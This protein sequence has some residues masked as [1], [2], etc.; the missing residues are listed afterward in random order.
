VQLTAHEGRRALEKK[1]RGLAAAI[2]RGSAALDWRMSA[3]CCTLQNQSRALKTIPH[4]CRRS[5]IAN[6]PIKFD[7][8]DKMLLDA[9]HI[10]N[11]SGGFDLSRQAPWG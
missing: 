2:F 11:N 9:C 5:T 8:D 10:S 3:C 1:Y 4:R 7:R 6:F